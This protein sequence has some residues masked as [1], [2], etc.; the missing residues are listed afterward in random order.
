MVSTIQNIKYR[1]DADGTVRI[2]IYNDDG[3]SPT[4]EDSSTLTL[5]RQGEKLLDAKAA[6]TTDNY[7]TYTIAA[8]VL[9]IYAEDMTLYV[10]YVIGTT[11]YRA[12]F[13]IT[14]TK[15]PLVNVVISGDL[16]KEY[17]KIDD[18]RWSSEANYQNIINEAFHQIEVD[19]EAKMETIDRT[20]RGKADWMVSA[21]QIKELI[22]Q[23]SFALIYKSFLKEPGD[24][25]NLLFDIHDE[26]YSNLLKNTKIRWDVDD[27]ADID[28][29]KSFSTV[30]MLR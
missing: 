4:L 8:A 16:A 21:I 28:K 6:I 18:D 10:D 25:F 29:S 24:I 17:P 14:C 13:L 12:Y 7:I 1:K 27:D 22:K 5:E 23:K 30:T 19:I 3:S 11:N 9:D 20:R 26:R 15:T 2:D